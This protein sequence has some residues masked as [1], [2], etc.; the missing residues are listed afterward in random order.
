M[1]PSG[2]LY[3]ETGHGFLF[4]AEPINTIT[5]AF[6]II[7]AIYALKEVRRAK[8]GMPFDLA[9]LLFLLFATGIGSFFWHALRTRVALAFDALPGLLFLFVLAGLWFR[10]LFGNLIGVAGALGLIALAVGTTALWRAYGV[11]FSGMPPAFAFAPA[12]A[13]IAAVG[14]FLA[15]ETARRYGRDVARPG[16]FAILS[17]LGAAVCR[18]I[19]LLVCDVLP[20][21]THFLWHILLSLAAYLGIVLLVRLKS[22][23]SVSL[24]PAS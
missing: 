4:M 20:T 24:R 2:P 10:A 19:D 21:G 14:A 8:V 7:A 22:A 23:K 1:T 6:I 5:N 17:A 11:G 13:S 16:A 18:S 3:C 9:L 12:F 15:T